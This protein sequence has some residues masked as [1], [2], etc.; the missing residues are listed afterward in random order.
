LAV[1]ITSG[2]VYAGWGRCN[3]RG[4]CAVDK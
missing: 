3:D 2:E 4:Q 1:T